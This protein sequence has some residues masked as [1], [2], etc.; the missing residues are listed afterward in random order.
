M[1]GSR[2]GWTPGNPGGFKPKFTFSRRTVSPDVDRSPSGPSKKM[3][4]E[5]PRRKLKSPGTPTVEGL[6]RGRNWRS[7]CS[8]GA[9]RGGRI[10]LHG[11]DFFYRVNRPDRRLPGS[12]PLFEA[13]SQFD[14]IQPSVPEE[15]WTSV[16]DEP[17]WASLAIFPTQSRCPLHSPIGVQG[18]KR[19]LNSF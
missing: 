3:N 18:G 13:A 14:R 8:L 15:S 19:R 4:R 7:A 16:L 12:H 2:G 1:P 5:A 10:G 6:R 11:Q 9:E 17:I